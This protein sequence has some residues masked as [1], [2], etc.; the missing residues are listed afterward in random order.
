MKGMNLKLELVYIKD[1]KFGDRTYVQNGVLTICKEELL[2]KLTNDIFSSIDL[3]LARPGESV[4][5]I[6]VKDVI[7]PRA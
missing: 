1:I 6:P 7:E 5:I 4:R 2:G 3:E